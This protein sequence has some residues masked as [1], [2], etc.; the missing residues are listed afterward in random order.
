MSNEYRAVPYDQGGIL[1]VIEST[2]R[3]FNLTDS[4]EQV[5]TAI[6]TRAWLDRFH[7]ETPDD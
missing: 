6:E 1:P 3:A 7:G 5:L 4:P 2:F